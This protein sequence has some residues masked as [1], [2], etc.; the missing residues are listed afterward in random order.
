MRRGFV[1][2]HLFWQNKEIA[3]TGCLNELITKYFLCRKY[4]KSHM[5]NPIWK[6]VRMGHIFWEWVA[7]VNTYHE[8]TSAYYFVFILFYYH[9]TDLHW[10]AEN[11]TGH[12]DSAFSN[13]DHKC[14]SDFLFEGRG[15]E[16]ETSCLHTKSLLTKL[17]YTYW[18]K[19]Q[20]IPYD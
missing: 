2:C 1:L 4:K 8:K 11:F 14:V 13:W 3:S 9:N 16:L 20:M 12:P 6:K 19:S 15:F 18:K 10:L 5:R 17:S 7:F